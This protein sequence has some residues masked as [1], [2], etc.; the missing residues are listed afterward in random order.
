MKYRL[1]RVKML[2]LLGSFGAGVRAFVSEQRGLLVFLV[3]MSVFRSSIAD[4]NQVPTGSMRPTIIEGDR[5][6]INKVAYD[7]Q[8]PFS[9]HSIYRHS[10]PERGDIVVI[11]SAASGK[12][13]IKRVIGIPGDSI[14]LEGNRLQ[15]NGKVMQY[16]PVGL[17]QNA[18]VHVESSGLDPRHRT[19]RLGESTGSSSSFSEREVPQDHYLVLGDN[20]G[21]SADSRYYGYVPRDEIIGRSRRV[22]MSFDTDR[23]YL[24]RSNRFWDLLDPG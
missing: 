18:L 15:V 9:Y 7:V 1:Q 11:K 12:R 14:A 16:Q 6:L 4:W 5:V 13:L 22:V 24:P 2:A 3:L 23:Y 19:V 21:N 20:R 8:L 10:N 17:D